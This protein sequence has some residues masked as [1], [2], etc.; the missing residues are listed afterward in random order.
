MS[1]DRD[2]AEAAAAAAR[3][4]EFA[5]NVMP[6]ELKVAVGTVDGKFAAYIYLQGN[7]NSPRVNLMTGGHSMLA[8]SLSEQQNL[9]QLASRYQAELEDARDRV[10]YG[11]AFPA[12]KA[13]VDAAIAYAVT[14]PLQ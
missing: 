2:P 11:V 7:R 9:M 5:K 4:A 13:K 8:G 12:N 10:A 3:R 6:A 14:H 1:R